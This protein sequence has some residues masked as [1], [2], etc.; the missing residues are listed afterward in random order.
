MS[1]SG[2][3]ILALGLVLKVTLVLGIAGVLAVALTIVGRCQTPRLADGARRRGRHSAADTGS[4][5]ASRA[6]S[7]CLASGRIAFIVRFAGGHA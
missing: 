6:G 1:Y 7:G 2:A 5:A 4:A 3:W